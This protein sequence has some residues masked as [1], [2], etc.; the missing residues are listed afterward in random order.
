MS[1]LVYYRL[2]TRRIL[3]QP[4]LQMIP[5]DQIL[6]RRARGC[7]GLCGS[8]C[9]RGSGGLVLP[10]VEGVVGLRWWVQKTVLEDLVRGELD[11]AR[12]QEVEADVVSGGRSDCGSLPAKREGKMRRFAG[13]RRVVCRGSGAKSGKGREGQLRRRKGMEYA[14]WH[15]GEHGEDLVDHPLRHVLWSEAEDCV[16]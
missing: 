14:R 4:F 13:L 11:R 15:V 9:G 10:R 7:S 1:P 2:T 3:L 6:W 5:R 16:G 8:V 12:A